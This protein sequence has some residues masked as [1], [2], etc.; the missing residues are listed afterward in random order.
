MKQTPKATNLLLSYIVLQDFL[1]AR[2]FRGFDPKGGEMWIKARHV[3]NSKACQ[4]KAC[5]QQRGR[6]VPKKEKYIPKGENADWIKST[7]ERRVA[8]RGRDKGGSWL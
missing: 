3:P 8:N 4:S 1:G 5:S 6:D 2:P 7:Y